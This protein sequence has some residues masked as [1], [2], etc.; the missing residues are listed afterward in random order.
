ML[1]RSL[2]PVEFIHSALPMIV[3]AAVLW[4]LAGPVAA[5]AAVSAVLAGTVLFPVLLPFI[6]TQDFS[7]KG[8]ILG[9][10]IAIPFAVSYGTNPSLPFWANVLAAATPLLIIPAAVS[11][12]ALN[13][14]G[15]TT[16]TSRTG[17]KKEIFR[18]VPAMVAMA[19]AGSLAGI[20]L[21]VGRL[22]G[23]I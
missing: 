12:A 7:T 19:A 3:A 6:P 16:F 20:A 9:A 2:T 15:C 8:L 22:I 1:F 23:V 10:I 4:F 14:T 13:F 21:G 11:Y 5:L 18:Y 17:V